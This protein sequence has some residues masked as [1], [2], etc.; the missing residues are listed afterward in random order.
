MQLPYPLA[1]DAIIENTE[2]G[3][4]IASQDRLWI[5]FSY[6]LWSDGQ[7]ADFRYNRLYPMTKGNDKPD[8]VVN[9][10]YDRDMIHEGLTVPVFTTRREAET[11]AMNWRHQILNNHEERK[12][13]VWEREEIPP[14]D[15]INL[16]DDAR[17]EAQIIGHDRGTR[18]KPK[19]AGSVVAW[20]TMTQMYLRAVQWREEQALAKQADD[21]P[22]CP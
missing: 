20:Q 1:L 10:C 21:E 8:E 6:D 3:Y 17:Y 11:F 12:G 19:F 14:V 16:G 5:A 18:D 2:I 22:S 4:T 9:T 13:T 7:Y 15:V